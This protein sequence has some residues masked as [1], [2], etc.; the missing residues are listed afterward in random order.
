MSN[1]LIQIPVRDSEEVISIDQLPE[2]VVDIIDALKSEIAPLRIWIQ[3][4]VKLIF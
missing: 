1:F 2:D 4:A 3:L